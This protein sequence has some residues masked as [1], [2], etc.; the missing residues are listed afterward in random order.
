MC[1]HR[2]QSQSASYLSLFVS[3]CTVFHWSMFW[4]MIT[5]IFSLSPLAWE[6]WGRILYKFTTIWRMRPDIRPRAVFLTAVLKHCIV[7]LDSLSKWVN[8]WKHFT[9]CHCQLNLLWTSACVTHSVSLL[10]LHC[11]YKPDLKLARI[12]LSLQEKNNV[13]LFYVYF[14]SQYRASVWGY[15]W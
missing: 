6:D 10:L 12:L 7:N 5:T 2:G 4:V 14:C 1:N 3:V 8:W 15:I 13:V 11:L 9:S